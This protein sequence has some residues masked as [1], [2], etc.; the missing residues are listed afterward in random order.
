MCIHFFLYTFYQQHTSTQFS[1]AEARIHGT[2]QKRKIS[3]EA[4]VPAD[5]SAPPADNNVV[6]EGWAAVGGHSAVIQQ[7]KEMVLL[8]LQYPEVFNHMGI[9]PPGGILFHGLPG[10]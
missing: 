8:P 6:S 7:L 1:K 5:Q 3:E 9:A 10:D 4:A 2:G